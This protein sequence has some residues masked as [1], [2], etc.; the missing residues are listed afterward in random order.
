LVA[1]GNGAR[2]I[3]GF[4]VD[5]DALKSAKARQGQPPLNNSGVILRQQ[6]EN[7]LAECQPQ[8]KQRRKTHGARQHNGQEPLALQGSIEDFEPEESHEWWL[9]AGG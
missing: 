1:G 6:I 7:I 8:R 4:E 2:G 3:G 9:V 5:H